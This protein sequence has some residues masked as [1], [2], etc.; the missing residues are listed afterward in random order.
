MFTDFESYRNYFSNLA[1]YHVDLAGFTY[2]GD[3]RVISD[4]RNEV[5]YPCLWLEPPSVDISDH[6]Y[7]RTMKFNGAFVIMKNAEVGD[8]D[9]QNQIMQ[10][11]YLISTQVLARM[12]KDFQAAGANKVKIIENSLRMDPIS[13]LFVDNDWGWRCEFTVSVDTDA[14]CY[15]S[16]K[17]T[18]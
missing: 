7:N 6:L 3:D 8:F 12:I 13:T 17:W 2:G 5:E 9:A 11:M 1:S 16:A 10:D 4:T 14:I 15:Q 18:S